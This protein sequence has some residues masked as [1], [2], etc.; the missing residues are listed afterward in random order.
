M[1]V[2]E[3]KGVSCLHCPDAGRSMPGLV[4]RDWGAGTWGP[5]GEAYALRPPSTVR[6]EL[7]WEKGLWDGDGRSS[8]VRSPTGLGRMY[9]KPI[10]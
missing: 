6:P 4:A 8:R 7:S 2:V 5:K 1:A 3:R 9:G 10:P